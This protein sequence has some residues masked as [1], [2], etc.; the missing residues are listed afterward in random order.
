[1]LSWGDFADS[2]KWRWVLASLALFAIASAGCLDFEKQ[3]MLV[4]FPKD[5]KDGKEVRALFV[6]HGLQVHGTKANDP[7]KAKD[8]K[9][10]KRDMEKAKQELTHLAGAKGFYLGDPLLLISLT[11][12]KDEKITPEEE[13]VL[14]VLNR[15]LVVHKGFFVISME[16]HL[17]F[18][19]PITLRDPATFL[20]WLNRELSRSFQD[21]AKENLLKEDKEHTL[22]DRRTLEMVQKAAKDGHTWLRLE[23]GQIR[24][25]MPGTPKFFVN[26]KREVLGL[27]KS[28]PEIQRDMSALLD[29]KARIKPHPDRVRK[30]LDDFRRL[31]TF[32]AQ[33]PWSLDQRHDQL[34][35]SLGWGNG[36]PL[37]LEMDRGQPP[38]ADKFNQELSDHARTLGVPVRKDVSIEKVLEKFQRAGSLNETR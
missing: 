23:P 32:L 22:W 34:T 28:I 21:M 12:Q 25:F 16:N 20:T 17:S 24:F 14:E 35:F 37:R 7:K 13:K 10:A 11:R 9:K 29:P 5:G 19:Q 15:H 18:C 38:A 3:T 8:L 27:D 33:T 36:L 4:V 2:A 31:L 26:L 6:Y 30:D 1:M